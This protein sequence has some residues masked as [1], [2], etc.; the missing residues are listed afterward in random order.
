M[1]SGSE[2]GCGACSEV[3]LMMTFPASRLDGC[4]ERVAAPA[5]AYG[6]A[7]R[8]LASLGFA[9]PATRV[10]DFDLD[11]RDLESERGFSPLASRRLNYF[12]FLLL[13]PRRGFSRPSTSRDAAALPP[14][15][16]LLSAPRFFGD[17]RGY[18][19]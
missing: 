11:L 7:P 10:D 19:D 15:G 6:P 2:M 8:S 12:F 18:G 16:L 5:A 13:L 14:E 4:R 17:G 1:S 3:M 9:S